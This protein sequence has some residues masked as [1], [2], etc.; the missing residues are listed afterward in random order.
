MRRIEIT[1]LPKTI[2]GK[3]RRT[4]L[5]RNERQ[6]REAGGVRGEWEFFEEDFPEL[7]GDAEGAAAR[8][9]S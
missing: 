2:S 8:V 3:I 5:N 1:E 6:K 7:K 4:E 9:A